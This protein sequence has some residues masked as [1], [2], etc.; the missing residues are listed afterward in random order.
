MNNFDTNEMIRTLMSYASVCGV[1]KIYVKDDGTAKA[2]EAA[3]KGVF[4]AVEPTLPEDFD[5]NEIGRVGGIRVYK[6]TL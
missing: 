1:T 6:E 3:Y 5:I 2:F 4:T